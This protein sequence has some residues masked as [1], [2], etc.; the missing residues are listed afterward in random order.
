MPRQADL[1]RFHL[2]GSIYESLL[3]NVS[4]LITGYL[5][6]KQQDP[7]TVFPTCRD[8]DPKSSRNALDEFAAVLDD[9]QEYN[10]RRDRLLKLSRGAVMPIYFGRAD[11]VPKRRS[12]S[13]LWDSEKERFHAAARHLTPRVTPP[14]FL[15]V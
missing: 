12:F 5:R 11:G 6:L 14:R 15:D 8:P 7:N 9:E 4:G 1:N 13:L 2:H 3:I 10:E